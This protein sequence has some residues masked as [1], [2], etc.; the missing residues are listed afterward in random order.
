MFQHIEPRFLGDVLA[1]DNKYIPLFI[2]L[3]ITHLV[4]HNVKHTIHMDWTRSSS[5]LKVDDNTHTTYKNT[6]NTKN[7]KIHGYKKHSKQTL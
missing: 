2:Y 7:T 1:A 6:K 4:Q 5:L 3:F